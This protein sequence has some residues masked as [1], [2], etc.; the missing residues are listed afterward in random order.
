MAEKIRPADDNERLSKRRCVTKSLFP[1]INRPIYPISMVFTIGMLRGTPAHEGRAH[2]S[3]EPSWPQLAHRRLMTVVCRGQCL[4][5]N[6][7][8][9]APDLV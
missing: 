6:C 2:A 4:K 3:G 9:L 5:L 8:M 7:R 1:A